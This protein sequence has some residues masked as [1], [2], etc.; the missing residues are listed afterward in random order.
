MQNLMNYIFEKYAHVDGPCQ[1]K[2]G[3]CKS[4]CIDCHRERYRPGNNVRYDCEGV[5]R[6]YL[7]RYFAAHV[8]Q[9]EGLVRDFILPQVKELDTIKALSLGGG[10]GVDEVPPFFSPLRV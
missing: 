3:D 9:T 5:K 10:P 2:C 8:A 4:T 1:P 7:V 6:V